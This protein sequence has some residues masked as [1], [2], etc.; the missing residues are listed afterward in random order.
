MLGTKI[1]IMKKLILP[2]IFVAFSFVFQ[3]DAQPE[4]ATIYWGLPN[5]NASLKGI[6]E[7]TRPYAE[8]G[9]M[10]SLVKKNLPEYR[11]QFFSGNLQRI[12]S[13]V[14]TTSNTCFAASL[15]K[16]DRT[17]FSY[18]TSFALLPAPVIILKKDSLKEV[19]LKKGKVDLS[20]LLQD[21]SFKGLAAEGRSFGDDVDSVLKNVDRS[22]VN[23]F[24]ADFL[25]DNLMVMVAKGRA[26]Y[27]F[28]H[29]YYFE[30]YQTV[31]PLIKNLVAM[32][33]EEAPHALG[34]YILCSRSPL[35]HSIVKR[36][37]DLIRKNIS[38]PDYREKVLK[39]HTS[40]DH[41]DSFLKAVDAFIQKRGKK[42]EIL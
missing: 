26:D 35:G 19:P 6:V 22:F 12:L 23:R 42:P 10:M 30:Q 27:T 18:M 28:E 25:A 33:M 37:D 24:S 8:S 21:K 11:H 13:E 34:L 38:L 2:L 3:A 20:K 4:I 29:P 17:T 40:Y 36:L 31:N 14:K 32:P 39:S 41:K 7:T 9:Y 1:T 5:L 15:Y 16:P